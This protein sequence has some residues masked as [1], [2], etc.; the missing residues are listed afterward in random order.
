[1]GSFGRMC[2]AAHRAG[3]LCAPSVGP[4]YAASRA[5][6]DQ[7]M[8]LRRSGRTYDEMWS[9]ALRAGADAVTI[10]SY[11]EWNEGTQIEP[12][13]D[14]PPGLGYLSYDGAYG[15]RGAEAP[16]AYLVRTACWAAVFSGALA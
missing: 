6:G 7:R 14:E 11:N 9:T 5:T 15:L 13:S 2:A 16:R 8:K 10:T 4:G 1:G 12:A 3:L